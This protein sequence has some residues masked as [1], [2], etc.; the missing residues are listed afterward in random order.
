MMKKYFSLFLV[1]I[2]MAGAGQGLAKEWP[3]AGVM[4][5]GDLWESFLPTGIAKYYGEVQHP[6]WSSQSHLV[7]VGNLD[8]S[9]TTPT[10]HYPSGDVHSLTWN[11]GLFLVE[12][13]PTGGFTERATYDAHDQ[14]TFYSY[15]VWHS[16]MANNEGATSN[17]DVYGGV[18]WVDDARTQ[19]MYEASFPTNLGLDVV[20]KTHQFS[21]NEANMNDF[22][23]CEIQLTNTGEQDYNCDGVVERSNHKIEA[24]TLGWE[25]GTFGSMKLRSNG[26]R[27]TGKWPAFTVGGYDATPD[28]DGNPWA[29]PFIFSTQIGSVDADGW[30]PDEARFVG[31]RNKEH[32]FND[33]WTGTQFIA[34]KAGPIEAGSAALDKKTIYDSH[35]I[36]EGVERGWFTTHNRNIFGGAYGYFYYAAGTFFENGG[37]EESASLPSAIR[38]DPNWFDVSQAYTVNDPVSF[39]T[40]VKPEA[41]RTQPMGDIKLTGLWLQNWERNF[42]GTLA[43]GIPAEDEMTVGSTQKTKFNFGSGAY[44]GVGPFSLEVGETITIVCAE[45]AGY[46]LKG[47]RNA[48]AAARFT[49]ESDY[50]V[51]TPPTM[52]RVAIEKDPVEPIPVVYWDNAAETDPDFAGY[53]VYK[54]S[55]FPKYDSNQFGIRFLDNYQHQTGADIGAT[56]EELVERYCEPIN[57]NR[58]IPEDYNVVWSPGTHGP[59]KIMADI[60]IAELSNYINTADEFER[61]DFAYRVQDLTGDTGIGYTY[62]YYVAAYSNKTGD[63]AGTSYTS[64]ESGKSNWNGRDGRWLGTYPYATSNVDYPVD[65]ADRAFMGA[66]YQNLVPRQ[67]PADLV[68]GKIKIQIKPNPYKVQAPHD[69]GLEHKIIFYNLP[70]HT[71]ITIL[72]LSGQIMDTMWYEGYTANDGTMFWDMFSKDGPEVQSGLY[73]WIAEYPGGQQT[74]YMGIMR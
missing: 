37:K 62:W 52:P 64:L 19:Q 15:A 39:A 71:R 40:I 25:D 43:P 6:E 1:L 23:L 2:L 7:R 4:C 18:D 51:P 69:V 54:V 22:I 21:M 47:A 55:A 35:P 46:R 30:A 5:A 65:A 41:E 58:S 57:P 16:D 20:F 56:N 10:N 73:I 3:G 36:G 61:P 13:D 60:P 26:T 31:Y 8:R 67:D 74:G 29:V 14:A 66:P 49:Y 17:G 12:F 28:P 32:Y 9:W 48:L 34:V 45:Y 44:E 24:M 42:P 27:W 38:P 59:W 33:I 63:I 70:I 11:Q 72:D 53:K 50:N 68:S